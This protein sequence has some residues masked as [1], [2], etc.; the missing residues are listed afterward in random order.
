MLKSY[1]KP[2]LYCLRPITPTKSL[3]LFFIL[4]TSLHCFAV[5]IENWRLPLFQLSADMGWVETS[6]SGMFWKHHSYSELISMISE[7]EI[8]DDLTSYWRVEPA[9]TGGFLFKED[10]DD[11]SFYNAKFVNDIRFRRL[12]FR[13]ALD[14]DSRYLEDQY[15]PAHRGRNA[16]G[17]IEEAYMQYNYNHGFL[18]LGRMNRNWGPFAEKSMLLSSHPYTYDALEWQLFAS[19][20]EF[21]KLFA[22]FPLKRSEWDTQLGDQRGDT[23][24]RYFAAHAL[25]FMLADWI[26]FGFFESVIFGRE[27]GIPDLSYVNPV[28]VY[29]VINLNRESEVNLMVGFHWAIRAFTDKIEWRGQV[30]IDDFQIDNAEDTGREQNNEPN[31]WG[32]SS[33]LYFRNLLPLNLSN[34]I[35]A[36]YKKSSQWLY[37]VDDR[38]TLRGERYSY[39]GRSL[40]LPENDFDR[41]SLKF[42]VIG[43][44][45][46]TASIETAYERKGE[47]NILSQWMDSHMDEDLRGL[48]FNYTDKSFPSGDHVQRTI[49][50]STEISGFFRNLANGRLKFSNRWIQNKNNK[51]NSSYVYDPLLH[52]ELSFHYGNWTLSLPD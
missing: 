52:F 24:N 43:E 4:F 44:N 36:Q 2:Y 37:T 31:H 15:F 28:S 48:P 27:S 49:E 38:N 46:W 8:T 42:A 18:R 26:T 41:T 21:R 25:N 23:M 13:Q 3:S 17:R 47:R 11:N 16:Q 32:I 22:A 20:F 50:L 12:F 5:P 34:L 39:L 30:A 35:K 40:G 7:H 19:F 33:A 29:S 14:V 6:P 51:R 45:L 9:L 1:L 10:H